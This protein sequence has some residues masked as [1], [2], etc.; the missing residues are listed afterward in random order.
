MPWRCGGPWRGRR[1]PV[2]PLD[3]RRDALLNELWQREKE[4]EA[5]RLRIR[6]LERSRLWWVAFTYINFVAFAVVVVLNWI[7]KG[8]N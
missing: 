5:L 1:R 3:L 8:V 6:R 4:I 7:V 2:E